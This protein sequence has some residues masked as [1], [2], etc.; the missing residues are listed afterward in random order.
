MF[1]DMVTT[2][3]KFCNCAVPCRGANVHLRSSET[4]MSM[5]TLLRV[6]EMESLQE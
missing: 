6:G 3:L 5:A 2:E 1:C 4:P